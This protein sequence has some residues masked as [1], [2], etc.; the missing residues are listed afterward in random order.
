MITLTN[1]ALKVVRK[2]TSEERE[3]TLNIFDEYIGPADDH[4]VQHPCWP[5]PAPEVYVALRAER[6]Y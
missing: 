6:G 2:M 5:I 3:Q 1:R 4:W